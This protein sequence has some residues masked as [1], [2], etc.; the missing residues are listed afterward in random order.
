MLWLSR[1]CKLAIQSTYKLHNIPKRI[2]KSF[3]GLMVF[4]YHVIG[5]LKQ[6]N[7]SYCTLQ[8][9]IAFNPYDEVDS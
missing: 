7:K 5:N 1:A 3:N 4:T 9:P 8:K 6:L 2:V